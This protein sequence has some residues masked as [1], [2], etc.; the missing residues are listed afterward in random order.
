[1]LNADL[2]DCVTQAQRTPI[3]A[4]IADQQLAISI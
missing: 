2:K 1:M 3:S 4:G